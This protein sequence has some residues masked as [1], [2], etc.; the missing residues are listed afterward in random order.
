MGF[1]DQKIFTITGDFV[2]LRASA[3]STPG[4][5]QTL[6]TSVVPGAKTREIWQIFVST[7]H[8][9][10]WRLFSGATVIASGRNAPGQPDSSFPITPPARVSAG[11]TIELKF[12]GRSGFPVTEVD[13]YVSA[14]DVPD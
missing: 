1:A 12:L 14:S 3:A 9:G 2:H 5:E 4:I 13:A 7:Q 10:I 8:P 11:T 6:I